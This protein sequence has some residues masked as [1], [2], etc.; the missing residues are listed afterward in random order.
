MKSK[1]ETEKLIKVAK[2]YKCQSEDGR[3]VLNNRTNT[4]E[5][6]SRFVRKAFGL[7]EKTIII[8]GDKVSVWGFKP[9]SEYARGELSASRIASVLIKYRRALKSLGAINTNF[10]R[11]LKR[12]KLQLTKAGIAPDIIKGLSSK[13]NITTLEER[14]A[15]LKRSYPVGEKSGR[16]MLVRKALSGI[17][18]Y[19]PSYYRMGGAVSYVKSI[20][21]EKQKTRLKEKHDEKIRVNPT[22]LLNKA[23][24]VLD[25]PKSGWASL[26]VALCTVTGR[27]PTEIMKT[28]KLWLD[29][30]TPEHYIRFSGV[31]KSR[32]RKLD[33]DFGEWDIP[34]FH[35][36]V[37]I[38]KSL[39]KVR[40]E[41]KKK[42]KR[43]DEAGG[44]GNYWTGGYLRY[45]N[46]N[47]E[48]VIASIFDKKLMNDVD[49][50][51][52]V[53]GQYNGVLNDEL[54]RWFESGDIE[55]K[56]LRAI[57]TKMVWEREKETSSETYESMSTRILCYGKSSISEAV[58][59]YA[60]IELSDK[61][62]K[63]ELTQGKGKDYGNNEELIEVLN[64]ADDIITK[65]SL[66]APKLTT[67]HHWAK[68]RASRGLPTNALTAT[69]IRKNC[70]IGG[71][72][73]NADTSGLYLIL[74][75]LIDSLETSTKIYALNK[76]GEMMVKNKVTGKKRKLLDD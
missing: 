34:V 32:D 46:E 39:R 38:I 22:F 50:N 4:Y 21:N 66:R 31:L 43:D 14:L 40:R 37:V 41:L 16:G 42:E 19:H 28:A 58:K 24:D 18:M 29:E 67:I 64:K 52:A 25:N 9:D 70:L 5:I 61:V 1:D 13:I 53:N 35:D 23:R 57:Y 72:K 33:D 17:A 20:T 68:N 74:V 30:Q 69:Y 15:L 51:M 73:I 27:R 54:R 45:V 59:H 55:I 49:H 26:T 71:K 8:N 76:N 11:T 75:G 62:D 6:Y 65:K 44:K 60:A 48:K 63:I 56:S 2:R 3:H 7:E 10:E 12:A 36:P 47:G